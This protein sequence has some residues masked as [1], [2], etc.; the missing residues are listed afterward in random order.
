MSIQLPVIIWTVICFCLFALVMSKLLFEPVLKN[1]DARKARIDKART[2][3]EA[4][5]AALIAEREAALVLAA[6]EA[7][8]RAEVEAKALSQYREKAAE[9]KMAAAL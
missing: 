2:D 3:A 6:E 5:K 1:M 9:E 7:K 8:K 4:A